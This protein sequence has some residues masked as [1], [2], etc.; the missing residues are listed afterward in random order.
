MTTDEALGAL[1]SILAL[2]ATAT[3][4]EILNEIKE[5]KR[6]NPQPTEV[7]AALARH[8]GVSPMFLVSRR[9]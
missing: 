5:L 3:L 1:R 9:F 8:W 6:K 2:P 7:E 4:E